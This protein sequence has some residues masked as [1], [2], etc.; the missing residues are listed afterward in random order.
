MPIPSAG[1]I[2]SRSDFAA[3]ALALSESL[4]RDPAAFENR[5]LENFLEALAAWTKDMD[6]VFR[7]EGK[8]TPQ[9][10]WSL[11]ARILAA[12]TSYE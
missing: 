10:G 1:G 6:G 4:K 2:Q 5:T 12:A 11:F 3:F 8:E 7:N 9:P